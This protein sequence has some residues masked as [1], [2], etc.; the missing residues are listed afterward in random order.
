MDFTALLIGLGIVIILFV[1]GKIFAVLT[2]IFVTI[3]II[4]IIAVGF[5]L[6]QNNHKEVQT[7][8]LPV[9]KLV[10]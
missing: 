8:N 10:I 4:A 2:K 9:S 6:W 3:I 1:V 7:S 5:F